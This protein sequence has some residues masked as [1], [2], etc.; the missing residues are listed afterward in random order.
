MKPSDIRDLLLLAALWGGSFLLMRIA[1]PAFGPVLLVELRVLLAALFLL[2][3]ILRRKLLKQTQ[4]K[5]AP[6]LVVGI[7]NSALPFVLFSWALLVLS[8]GFTAIINATAPLFGALIGIMLYQQALTR[9]KL[10]GLLIG[11]TG[12]TALISS[13]G[14]LNL[15][16]TLMTLVAAFGAAACYGFAANYS[17]QRLQQTPALV[18]AFGSQLAAA[19]IL[20]PP[21]LFWLPDRW[22]SLHHWLA[23]I[24]L[25]IACTG[26]AYLLYFRLINN[27]G[28]T[29]AISV[30]FLVP[31]F[32]MTWGWL[33]INEPVNP[34]MIGS[35]I[36][37]LAGTALTTGLI[38]HIMPN[39]QN[40]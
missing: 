37:I 28:A 29:G 16:S 19:V 23:V 24:T 2:P 26:I 5:A 18:L 25:G 17:S 35:C 22:P 32:A 14:D 10:A 6:L 30:T 15:T 13:K 39:A 4:E 7:F 33:I 3:F 11:L 27:I 38:R 8:T 40:S 34:M 21:A 31:A 12:V 9:N 1:A 36:I 20:L